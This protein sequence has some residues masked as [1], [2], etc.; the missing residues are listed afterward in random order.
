MKTVSNGTFVRFHFKMYSPEGDLLADTEQSPAVYIHGMM[1]TDPEGLG[2]YLEGKKEGFVGSMT[3]ENAFGPAMPHEEAITVFPKEQLGG[4]VEKGM[5][6]AA[7]IPGKGEIPM[8]V[9]D[10]RGDDV[11]VL[12]GHPLAGMNIPFDVEIIEVRPS[13]E[14]DIQQLQEQFQE[15]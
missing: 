6:F 1:Q 2:L 14:A 12:M 8:T 7:N 13:T 9:M 4:K 10:I 5:M 11:M 15:N 3:L